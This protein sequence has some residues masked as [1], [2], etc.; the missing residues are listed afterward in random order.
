[1]SVIYIT[2]LLLN[3]CDQWLNLIGCKKKSDR[4]KAIVEAAEK[5]LDMRD[6]KADQIHALLTGNGGNT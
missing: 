3:I 6:V 2:R 5:C 1:M 4:I